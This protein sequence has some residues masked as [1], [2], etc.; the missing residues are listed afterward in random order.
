MAADYL[1]LGKYRILGRRVRLD[2]RSEIDIVAVK[3]NVLVFVEV[4]TRKTELFG[5]PVESVKKSKKRTLSRAAV[6]YL[7]K[8]HFRPVYIR[9]DVVEVVGEEG[10]G[11]P[12]VRHI[13]NAFPLDKR[14][15]LP[16]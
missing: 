15:T 2:N 5:S 7:K 9:F 8:L 1:E 4:K 3:D 11:E 12:V 10:G 13:E 16:Y 14:Y 6:R